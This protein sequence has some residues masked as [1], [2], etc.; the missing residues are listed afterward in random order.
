MHPIHAAFG[1]RFC[2]ARF[3]SRTMTP[4]YGRR[5]MNT[6][7][8]ILQLLLLLAVVFYFGGFIAQPPMKFRLWKWAAELVALVFLIALVVV[9][10][11]THPFLALLGLLCM[12]LI[13]F[14]ILEVR[15][16]FAHQSH[17]ATATP[18]LSLRTTGKTPAD[19]ADDHPFRE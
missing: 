8:C 2:F 18:F 1:R 4:G 12:A 11:R 16:R 9:E 13:S 7:N 15:R 17:R 3:R 19:L 14:A 10:V 6:M 5:V